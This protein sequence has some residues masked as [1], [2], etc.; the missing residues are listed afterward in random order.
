[1]V[2]KIIQVGRDSLGVP[3]YWS[4]Q[5]HRST[6]IYFVTFQTLHKAD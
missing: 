1:M 3:S 2:V 6:R 4:S 5:C